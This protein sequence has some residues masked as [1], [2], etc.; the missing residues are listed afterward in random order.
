MH[1]T[2]YARRSLVAGVLALALAACGK[3]SGPSEF[4]PQGTSADMAAAEGA[5]ASEQTSSVAAI[6][7]DISAVLYGSPLVARSAALA[8][9]KPSMASA[10][11]ARELAALV[12]RPSRGIQA[13]VASIPSEV[14]GTTFVWDETDHLYVASD[15]SGAPA[16]G[17]RFVLYA[18]DPVQLRPVEPVVEVGYVD[19]IDRSTASAIDVGVKVVEGNVVYLDYAVKVNATMSG[20]VAT[21]SGAASNGSTVATF[22]LKSTVSDNA[23]SPVFTVDYHVAVPSRDLSLDWTATLANISN[24]DVPITLDLSISGPNGN[25]RIAGTYGVSG[26]SLTVKV[27]GDLLAT[28]NLDDEPI[29]TGAGGEPLTPEEEESLHTILQFYMGST[30]VFA[31][32]FMPPVS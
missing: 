14:L 10:R 13:S 32:L 29:V 28:V 5:F 6:G 22:S 24:T 11:F 21:V 31:S 2:H 1:V 26:G 8:T 23:G 9:S 20:G 12:P 16:S 15:L 19:I 3:E 30:D 25:V 18:V 4:D 27:N 17:V 7:P